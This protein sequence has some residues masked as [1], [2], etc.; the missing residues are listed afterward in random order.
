MEDYANLQSLKRVTYNHF[1]AKWEHENKKKQGEDITALKN[2]VPLTL[3]RYFPEEI[4]KDTNS[5][6]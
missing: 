5:L 4:E 6:K 2:A 3:R 1:L